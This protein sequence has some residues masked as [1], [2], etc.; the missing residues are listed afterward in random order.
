MKNIFFLFVIGIFAL[1]SCE[2]PVEIVEGCT[3]EEAENYNPNANESNNSC[4]YA[5][6]AYLGDFSGIITCGGLIPD[7]SPFTMSVTEGLTGN[8]DV[9]IEIKDT[10]TA[11]PI[12]NGFARNDSLLIPSDTHQIEIY[13]I[14]SDVEITGNSVFQD[15]EKT[16]I[17]GILQIQTDFGG[18]PITDNCIFTA[19][20]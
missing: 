13:G 11:F 3:D 1:V 9:I 2:D 10:P 6:E 16:T 5:R 4:V 15:T 20:K 14:L 12:V 17:E 18:T 19:N 8:N 7:P